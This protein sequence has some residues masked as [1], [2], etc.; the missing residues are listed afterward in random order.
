M[1][2]EQKKGLI[3]GCWES[4]LLSWSDHF[5]KQFVFQQNSAQKTFKQIM[6]KII[7]ALC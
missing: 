6:I 1:T 2:P 3:S 5:R 4:L 7:H